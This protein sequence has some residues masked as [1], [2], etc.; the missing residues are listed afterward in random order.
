MTDV[1]QQVAERL[2][3][4]G[5]GLPVTDHDIR[6]AGEELRSRL[7]PDAHPRMRP[8][9]LAVAASVAVL[10]LVAGAVA[11]R[12]GDEESAPNLP[13]TEPEIRAPDGAAPT[14]ELLAG[15]WKL[16]DSPYMM[17]F[18]ADGTFAFDNT[19]R[20]EEPSGSGTYRVDGRAIEFTMLGGTLF[21][22]G[23]GCPGAWLVGLPEEGRLN[24]VHT[25]S[26]ITAGCFQD[27]AD[28]G[29]EGVM[30]RVS[31]P[32]PASAAIVGDEAGATELVSV[33]RQDEFNGLWLQQE[34][35]RLLHLE[36]IGTYTV[37]DD[38]Q[39]GA[40]PDD[41]GNYVITQPGVLTLTSVQGSKDCA[42]GDST[43]LEQVRINSSTLIVGT[44]V[45][46]CQGQADLSGSWVLLA[47]TPP[48][49]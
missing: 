42:A 11:L 7:D 15:I 35:G 29:Q 30:T 24:T 3:A 46:T 12:G 23:F 28:V 14:V 40:A 17:R 1:E 31:P 39:L 32:S 5:K 33:G 25:R 21:D 22:A 18:G 44:S 41:G 6:A 47:G 34:T 2:Q 48:I 49:E 9:A 43:T 37:A 20:L 27:E 16:D 4:Y 26:P 10:A 36:I 13:A 38:G 19:G 8:W 45:S